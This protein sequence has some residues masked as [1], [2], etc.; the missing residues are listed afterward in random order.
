[1]LRRLLLAFAS[2]LVLWMLIDLLLHRLF[3]AAIY[4]SSVTLW[5]PFDKMNVPLI[6]GA[7]GALISSYLGAYQLLVRPKSFV[8]GLRFGAFMGF[9][10]GTAVGFGT[11]IH[12]PI[13]LS[14]AWGW[15]VGACLKGLVA[16]GALGALVKDAKTV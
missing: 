5:R 7:T 15:F 4:E 16:G 10:L 6:Y 2:I 3:L 1:M 11:Y 14:L 8:A 12:M 9:T 13:P